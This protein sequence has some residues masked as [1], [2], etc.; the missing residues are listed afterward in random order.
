MWTSSVC[1]PYARARENM[2]DCYRHRILSY[3]TDSNGSSIGYITN[4]E[5]APERNYLVPCSCGHCVA[6]TNSANGSKC[7][8]DPSQPSNSRTTS[9]LGKTE[10]RLPV[11]QQAAACLSVLQRFLI[12]RKNNFDLQPSKLS[13][14]P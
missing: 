1:V 5:A 2:N 14:L 9:E 3:Q 4:I 10:L 12:L 11:S 6:A 13:N 8:R 7:K